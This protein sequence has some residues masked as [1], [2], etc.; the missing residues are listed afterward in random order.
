MDSSL[1]YRGR[2]GTTRIISEGHPAVQHRQPQL[3]RGRSDERGKTQPCSY[4]AAWRVTDLSLIIAGNC[5]GSSVIFPFKDLLSSNKLIELHFI[6]V[7]RDINYIITKDRLMPRRHKQIPSNPTILSNGIVE[8]K[9]ILID[10]C[11]LQLIDPQGHRIYILV[12]SGTH[13]RNASFDW[14]S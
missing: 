1:G 5:D 3:G 2:K 13:P 14:T 10:F 8:N 12:V 6:S 9:S 11:G 7:K 4:G